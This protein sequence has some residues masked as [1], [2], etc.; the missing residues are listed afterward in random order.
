MLLALVAVP[1]VVLWYRRLLRVRAARRAELAA[2]GL[3]APRARARRPAAAPAARAAARRA[4]AAGGGRWR[5]RRRPCPQPR[6]EGTVILAFDVSASMAAKDLRADPDRRGEGRRAHVRG[7]AAADRAD[8]ASW[9]SAAAGWSPR[10]PTTDKADGARRDRPP[11][12]AGR[13]RARRA[14][15][16]RRSRR[17]SA[18][19]CSLDS[20]ARQPG[21]S[22]AGRTSAT[23]VG[24]DRP[25]LRRREH[26]RP[27]PAR[28]RRPRVRRRREGLPDRAG[29][30][31]GHGAGDRRLP[32]RHARSTSRLLREIADRTDGTYFAAGRRRRRWPRSTTRSTLEWTVAER[33]RRA[34][35]PRSRPRPRLL[36][37]AGVGLS[38]LR[39]GRAV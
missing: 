4:G 34:H 29:Q 39:F 20:G 7:E 11:H 19:R 6:R 23:T 31:G 36:L 35:R 3:V 24:R 12:P 22:R 17:S 14:G 1:L 8:R 10:S 5:G 32:G 15:C 27:R 21:S 28:R 9:R 38:V 26:Q 37:L 13:H 2:L 30:A 16:R 18:S 25:A 33:A